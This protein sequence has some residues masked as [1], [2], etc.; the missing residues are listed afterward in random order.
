MKLFY[1]LILSASCNFSHFYRRIGDHAGGQP[2]DHETPDSKGGL[3]WSPTG[4]CVNQLDI[5]ASM[6][7]MMTLHLI[8]E[9]RNNVNDLAGI[10]KYTSKRRQVK[11]A[12]PFSPVKDVDFHVKGGTYIYFIFIFHMFST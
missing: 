1:T 10:S 3:N 9:L 5:P 2:D 8:E 6:K 7:L 11:L 4:P 12:T